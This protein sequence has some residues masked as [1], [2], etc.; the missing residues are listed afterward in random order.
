M[1]TRRFKA[2]LREKQPDV[3]K[4]L[5]QSLQ[6]MPWSPVRLA[7]HGGKPAFLS[8]HFPRELLAG[9]LRD[10]TLNSLAQQDTLSQ[11]C[12]TCTIRSLSSRCPQS[13]LRATSTSQ[14]A[15]G[16]EHSSPTCTVRRQYRGGN[17]VSVPLRGTVDSFPPGFG[18]RCG[19]F[20]EAE[21]ALL[22]NS[23]TNGTVMSAQG[24]GFA[25]VI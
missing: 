23:I 25:R 2:V 12:R 11:F 17:L 1:F 24:Y 20:G 4:A 13:A 21:Q 16:H 7:A 18:R 8:L 9:T 5:R 6:W 10:T 14:T 15:N 3:D 22:R 19:R